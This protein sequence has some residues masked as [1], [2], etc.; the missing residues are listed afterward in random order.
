VETREREL[1]HSGQGDSNR[2]ARELL[3]LCERTS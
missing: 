2:A 1:M 3:V